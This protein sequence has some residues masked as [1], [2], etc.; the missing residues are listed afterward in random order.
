MKKLLLISI[1]LMIFFSPL[2][3][4]S[5]KDDEAQ[6]T[7]CTA[8]AESLK[9]PQ[10]IEETVNLINALPKPVQLDCFLNALQAPLKVFAVNSTS[11]AQPA[12]G[13]SSPRI[14]ILK[15]KLSLSVVPA[16]AGKTLLELGEVLSGQ[17]FKGEIRFP[18]EN[19]MTVND[20]T[21]YLSGGASTSSC[22]GCHLNETKQIYKTPN[23]LFISNIFRPDEAKR[24][25][26][27]FM[28][29]QAETCD[30]VTNKFRC[31][32][33]KAIYINGQATDSAFTY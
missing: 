7:D 23:Q 20:I 13:A 12:Q 31:D 18:V 27:T 2:G 8:V 26:Q 28:K 25:G 14:F 11:S 15:D 16:G 21:Q 4:N 19:T 5:K 29:I 24:V 17:S 10:T 33:L 3:C 6:I 1:S 9:N 22:A 32:I 30:S